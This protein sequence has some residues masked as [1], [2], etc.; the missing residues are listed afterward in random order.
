MKIKPLG[1]NQ[2]E[3]ET[4]NG[5]TLFSY[6]TPVACFLYG[7]GYFRTSQKWSAT[8]SK[9]INRWLDGNTAQE[10]PQSFFDDLVK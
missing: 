9:H 1:A 2:T 3:L 4:G 5:L 6:E 7:K 8:T 10:K